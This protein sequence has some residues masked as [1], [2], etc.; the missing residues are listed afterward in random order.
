VNQVLSELKE[1]AMEIDVEFVK[2]AIKAIGRIAISLKSGA[3]QCVSVLSDLIKTK[4]NYVIQ[5]C[6]IVIKDIFR[7]YPKQYEKVILVLCENLD[8]LEDPE[9]KSSMI[10]IIGEYAEKI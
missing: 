2:R 3:E 1:Y 8:I 6:I 7:K 9:A 4:I 5:E 10:W